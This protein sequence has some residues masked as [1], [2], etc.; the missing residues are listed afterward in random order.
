MVV[1]QEPRL[2]PVG[3]V[4]GMVAAVLVSSVMGSILPGVPREWIRRGH[5]TRTDPRGMTV[6]SAAAGRNRGSAGPPLGTSGKSAVRSRFPGLNFAMRLLFRTLQLT[7]LFSAFLVEAAVLYFVDDSMVRAV[8]GVLLIFPIVWIV[9]RSS[10]AKP[11]SEPPDSDKKRHFTGLRA[12]VVQLLDEIRRLN[13]MAVD[14]ERGFRDHDQAMR[15]MDG[16]ES[17]LKEIIS[18][19]RSTAGQSTEYAEHGLVDEGVESEEGVGD[20]TRPAEATILPAEEEPN[21]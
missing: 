13:W 21:P 19:I 9:T 12:Q 20:S 4:L 15:E 1:R 6:E 10:T 5:C 8:V 17:R 14:A 3:V 11:I 18:E 7:S 16:I 2:A